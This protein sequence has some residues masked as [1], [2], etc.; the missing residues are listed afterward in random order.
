MAF[1][2]RIVHLSLLLD[3]LIVPM[4]SAAQGVSVLGFFTK[5]RKPD[6]F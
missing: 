1:R 3:F 2:K 6:S 4:L 5:D